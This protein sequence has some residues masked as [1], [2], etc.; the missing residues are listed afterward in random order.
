MPVTNPPITIRGQVRSQIYRSAF[1]ALSGAYGF[2]IGD[3]RDRT[4][5]FALPVA[6]IENRK[7][8]YD[9]TQHLD[10]HLTAAERVAKFTWRTVCGAFI[11]FDTSSESD[12]NQ[13]IGLF[14]DYLIDRKLVF[15]LELPTSGGESIWGISV[16]WAGAFPHSGLPYRMARRASLAPH[17]NP[18]RV[19][20]R[21]KEAI[22]HESNGA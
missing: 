9:A 2:L 18:R 3:W 4:I 10:L 21:W 15:L 19:H 1:S 12:A 13:I 22:H 14:I 5:D 11:S 20:S 6:A 16:F 7:Y 8:F 17:H